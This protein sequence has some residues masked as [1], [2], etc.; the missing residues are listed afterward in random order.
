MSP[1]KDPVHHHRKR[2]TVS[3]AGLQENNGKSSILLLL[4]LLP[5]PLRQLAQEHDTQSVHTVHGWQETINARLRAGR[6]GARSRR[7]GSERRRT[8]ITVQYHARI[9]DLLVRTTPRITRTYPFNSTVA[10]ADRTT[11][12]GPYKRIPSASSVTSSPFT[13]GAFTSVGNAHPSHQLS[14]R[15]ERR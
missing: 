12:S 2:C 10:Q 4:L 13:G 5:L 6:A 11:V 15:K 9:V 8:N 3:T 1:F 7:R 14:R